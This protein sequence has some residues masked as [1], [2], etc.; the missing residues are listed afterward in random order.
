[1]ALASA[2]WIRSVAPILL[3]MERRNNEPIDAV[4]LCVAHDRRLPAV[5]VAVMEA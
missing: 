2:D 3:F 4:P 1:M 5:E